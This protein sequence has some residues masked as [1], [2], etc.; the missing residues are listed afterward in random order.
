MTANP[1]QLRNQFE[2]DGYMVFPA[3]VDQDLVR[4]AGNDVEWLI[5][6]NPDLRPEK[7][8]HTLMKDDPFWVRLISD[9]RLLDIAEIFIGP[10][11]A[12]FA[13]HY[14]CKPP[15]DGLP[16]LWHQTAVTGRWNRWKW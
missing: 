1:N 8:Y 14:L 9:E 5:R 16:V 6:N 13:S 11:I 12:L 4:E 10:D 7:L 2:R 15:G 3:V